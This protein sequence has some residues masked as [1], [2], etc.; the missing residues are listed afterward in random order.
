[1]E[2]LPAALRRTLSRLRRLPSPDDLDGLSAPAGLQLGLR[3]AAN[4]IVVEVPSRVSDESLTPAATAVLSAM[5]AVES[6][7]ASRLLFT[8]ARGLGEVVIER[9][10]AWMLFCADVLAAEAAGE[11]PS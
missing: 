7:D 4:R 10:V 6:N 1:M 9:D 5:R 8:V 2:R 3:P 11:P